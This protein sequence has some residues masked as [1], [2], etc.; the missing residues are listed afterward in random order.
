M[1]YNTLPK[2]RVPLQFELQTS[3]EQKCFTSHTLFSYLEENKRIFNSL[4]NNEDVKHIMSSINQYEYIHEKV[5]GSPFS[6]SKLKPFS[7]TFYEL[8][9]INY[10]LNLLDFYTGVP[11]IQCFHFGPNHLSTIECLNTIREEYKDV[12]HSFE[13]G[14]HDETTLKDFSKGCANFMFFELENKKAEEFNEYVYELLKIISIINSLIKHNGTCIIQIDHVF[15]KVIIEIIFILSN[16]F[17]KVTI[18]KSNVTN[19][20]SQKKYII[21]KNY[22]K[23]EDFFVEYQSLLNSVKNIKDNPVIIQSILRNNLSYYFLN[24]IEETNIIIGQQ[25]LEFYDQLISVIK[26]KNKEDKIENIR[27]INIQKSIYW[28]EKYRIPYNKFPEKSIFNTLYE[29]KNNSVEDEDISS[30][31]VNYVLDQIT[32]TDNSVID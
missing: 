8:L 17:D 4:T 31:V 18:M 9:D 7:N 10:T 23:N 29:A 24:R 25:Q 5:P 27:H 13:G 28:C 20:F 32:S 30:F 21:C 3:T 11:S 6:V 12:H 2:I 16:M 15:Y 1:S 26:N 14:I 19:V 22:N